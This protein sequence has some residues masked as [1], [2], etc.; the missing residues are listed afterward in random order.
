MAHLGV[1]P[2]YSAG[3][4][5]LRISEVTENSPA[6]KAGL[7][8]GDMIVQLG[9]STVTDVQSLASGLRR[10]KPGDMVKVLVRRGEENVSCD[11]TLGRLQGR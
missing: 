6:A 2:D 5:G 7:K 10:H 8:A 3:A 4:K 1:I 11:V 9:E